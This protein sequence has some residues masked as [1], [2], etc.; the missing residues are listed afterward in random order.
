MLDL[1]PVSAAAIFVFLEFYVCGSISRSAWL[2]FSEFAHV[3]DWPNP[4]VLIGLWHAPKV[5]LEVG[6]NLKGALL[7]TI[8]VFSVQKPK[9]DRG[10]LKKKCQWQSYQ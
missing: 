6:E 4:K 10:S 3:F 5:G 1:T 8:P 2:P 9:N 7:P